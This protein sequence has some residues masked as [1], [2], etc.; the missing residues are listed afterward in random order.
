MDQNKQTLLCCGGKSLL[1][2]SAIQGQTKILESKSPLI[3]EIQERI[4]P[5][6]DGGKCR[7]D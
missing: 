1:I 3:A 4:T 7:N 5:L 2:M 6:V